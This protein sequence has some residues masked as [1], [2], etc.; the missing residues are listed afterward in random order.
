LTS[1]V[2][3][4]SGLAFEDYLKKNIFDPLDM[5]NSYGYR[6]GKTPWKANQ[7]AGYESNGKLRPTDFLDGVLGDKGIYSTADD[8]LK[9]DQSFYSKKI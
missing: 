1:I 4:V 8:L 3:R 2:E 9:F 7:T 5:K 6:K